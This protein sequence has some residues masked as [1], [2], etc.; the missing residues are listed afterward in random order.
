[1]EILPLSL[2]LGLLALSFF[3]PLRWSVVAYIVLSAVDFYSANEGI[4][5]F[6][7]IK[8]IGYPIVLLWRLRSYAGPPKMGVAPAAWILFVCYVA[9]ASFWSQFPLS[10]V[11][12]VVELAASFLICIALVRA[13]KAGVLTAQSVFV[14]AT[15]GVLLLGVLRTVFLPHWGDLA[16][17]FSGFTTAQAYASLLGSLYALSLGIKGQ[18]AI[19][20]SVLCICLFLAVLADGSR[21]WAIGIIASTF[22]A[23][24]ISNAKFWV[25]IFGMAS[26]VLFVVVAVAEQD[27]IITFASR[28]ARTNRVADTLPLSLKVTMLGLRD[29]AP[30]IGAAACMTESLRPLKRHRLRNWLLDTGHPMGVSCAGT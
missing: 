20:R 8:G 23:L 13:S 30:T 17:R 2:Y 4:G 22:V 12:L 6:N 5:I 9:V 18:S 21:I 14:P 3:G 25:K 10:A 7:A 16:T 27:S 24:L 19:T 26:I 28:L 1:M 15:V 11:K 29:S